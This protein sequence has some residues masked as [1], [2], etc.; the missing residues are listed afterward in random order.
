[1]TREEEYK[2]ILARY[3]PP[4]AVEP[5]YSFISEN[6]V[7]F[8][9]S[10]SRTSK[11][12]DYRCPSPEHPH[13]EI[14]VNGDLPQYFFLM[15]LL[16]EMA[17]MK[18]FLAYGRKVQPHGHEWQQQYRN[19]LIEYFNGGHFPPE[20]YPLFKKY[21]SHIPLN[22]AAGQALEKALK[23]YGL[24]ENDI[25]HL[26]LSDIPIGSCFRLQSKPDRTFKNI[27]KRRTRHL[28]VDVKTN[29]RYLISGSAEVINE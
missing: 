26:T 9:I 24:E 4:T 1:M 21:T 11:L 8:K 20:T 7:R 25:S 14:S 15:V 12:G 5:I 2:S 29:L 13:H 28:C 22:R 6:S 16:H 23:K 19:L 27:E 18:T 17:H 10:A 3:L